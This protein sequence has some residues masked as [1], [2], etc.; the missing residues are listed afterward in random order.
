MCVCVSMC[1]RWEGRPRTPPFKWG[2]EGE[3]LPPHNT[4]LLELD[5]K[6]EGFAAFI[7]PDMI[8]AEVRFWK[9]PHTNTHQHTQAHTHTHTHEHTYTHIHRYTHTHTNTLQTY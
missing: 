8:K 2:D 3:I 5:L 4:W 6:A 9:T 7:D 1:C